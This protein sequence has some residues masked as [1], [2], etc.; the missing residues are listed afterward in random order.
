MSILNTLPYQHTGTKPY[1]PAACRHRAPPAALPTSPALEK[2][3]GRGDGPKCH[4]LQCVTQCLNRKHSTF[5][6][7]FCDCLFSIFKYCNEHKPLSFFYPCSFVVHLK[8]TALH[9]VLLLS[10]TNR[11][12]RRGSLTELLLPRCLKFFLLHW[13]FLGVFPCLP[14]GF[15]LVEGQFSWAYVKPSVTCLR[16]KRA[17]QINFD[18]IWFDLT[19]TNC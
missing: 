13:V 3:G 10:F 12:W 5:V 14:W 17:I 18:L 19:V 9:T 16:V 8:H 2:A 15:R 7:S 4:V 6:I 11:L 1:L